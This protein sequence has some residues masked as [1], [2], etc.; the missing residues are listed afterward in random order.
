MMWC[1]SELHKV[2]EWNDRGNNELALVNKSRSY[3]YIFGII[4]YENDQSDI[5]ENFF[6]YD[7]RKYNAPFWNIFKIKVLYFE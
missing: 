4:F 2:S 6:S 1:L 5:K 7:P 3:I